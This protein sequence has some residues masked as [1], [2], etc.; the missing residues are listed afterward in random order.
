MTF[1]ELNKVRELKKE[2]EVEQKKLKAL[3]IVIGA[4]PHKYGQ[5]EEG[6]VAEGTGKSPFESFTIQIADT[7][8]K[9]EKLQQELTQAVPRLTEKIQNEVA[10]TDEQT[11]LIYRYVAC[12]FFR[13]I[14]F[15]MGYSERRVY[16][17]HEQIL[18]RL[19]SISVDYSRQSVL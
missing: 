17:V 8:K 15:L 7:E 5:S 14:G 16:Q 1:S 18:K 13:D 4:L 9:I 10:N 11:L 19:Q 2:I 12:K 3:K 6:G